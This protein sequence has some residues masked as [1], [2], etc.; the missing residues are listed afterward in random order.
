MSTRLQQADLHQEKAVPRR[1]G[2]IGLGAM[3]APM[4]RHLLA[5]G[6]QLA[7]WARRPEAA[8]ALVAA[9]ATL[10]PTPAALATRSEVVISIVT[11]SADVEA[12]A[13]G[14]QGL[15][16]GFRPGAI[17]VDMSTI[18]PAVARSLAARYARQ[19]VGWLDAPVSG[20]EQGA[21]EAT[22][23]IMVGGE[24]DTLAA[25][26]GL[27]GVLGRRIVHVGPAGAGQV[28]KACNQMIMVA[29]IQACAEAMRLAQAH[30]L[31]TERVWQALMGGSAA[32]R[33]LEVMGARMVRRDFAAGIEARLHH[34]DFG[35]LLDEAARLGVALPVAAQVGQQLNA[36]MA[37]GGGRDDTAA[38]LRVLEHGL[39]AAPP[40]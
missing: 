25:V 4:A 34:K 8:S 28:A 9:G 19:G 21:I 10:C 1:V 20:G 14:P 11:G 23:A 31:D 38:L 26:S 35:I 15:A 32:S 36:L 24:A 27:L 7:L 22:L 2:L 29:A 33:V 30:Q 40:R 17:H 6:H 5:A 39:A 3:G 13:C 12:L 16:C 18:A 37:S